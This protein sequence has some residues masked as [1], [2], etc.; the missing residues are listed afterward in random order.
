VSHDHD[1]GQG[2]DFKVEFTQD[3]WDDFYQSAEKIWSGQPNP[4]LVAQT[5][6]LT[7]GT[8]LDAGSGEGGDAIWLAS[9]GW[10]VTAVDVSAVVLERAAANAAAHGAVIAD[11]ITWRHEDLYATGPRQQGF[12]LVSAQFIHFRSPGLESMHRRLAAAVRPGGTLLVVTHHPDDLRA[13]VGRSGRAETLPSAGELAAVLDPGS[14]DIL[15]AAAIGRPA[16][17]LDGQ[18]VT[19]K[20]TVLRAVRRR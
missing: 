1:H 12:D 13:N 11:R 15:V 4:Q 20:D 17:D 9:Q 3:F 16:T 8:A 6:D 19:V 2:H 14:W 5:A 10:T 18:P 7:P